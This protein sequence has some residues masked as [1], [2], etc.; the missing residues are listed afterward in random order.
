[1]SDAASLEAQLASTATDDAFL[2]GALNVLQPRQG[3]RAGLDGV[4]LAATVA[5]GE[6]ERVLDVGAGVGV[7]GLAVAR[8]LS[9][10]R[11]TLVERDPGLAAL[12][13]ANIARNGLGGRVQ[14]IEADIMRPLGESLEL[15]AEAGR[16]DHVV[17]NPPYH[18]EGHGTAA[19]DPAKAAANAMPGGALERWVRFMAAMARPGGIATLVHRADALGEILAALDGRFGGAVIL[20]LHP[21]EGEPASRVLVQAVKGS[22]APLELCHGLVLHNADHSF[23]PEVDAILRGGAPLLVRRAPLRS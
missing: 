20:P 12:A 13:R 8:R 2:G 21:R 9:D 17:A 14:L 7:V 15:A 23:R 11:A 22:R 19:G 5:A 4:L 10:L 6:G 1:V 18:V 3:Y 16:F